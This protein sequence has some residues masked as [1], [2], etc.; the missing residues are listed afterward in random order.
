MKS[1]RSHEGY[2]LIDHSQSPGTAEVPGGTIYESATYTCGHCQA[3]V[4]I[5]PKRTRARGFC[6]KC[7]HRVCDAC[8]FLRV[9]TGFCLT[10]NRVVYEALN[11]AEKNKSVES[12][13]GQFLRRF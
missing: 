4:V 5:E 11:S 8:E 10:F 1:L 12:V 13:V 9:K 6:L 3:I 2:L 7:N